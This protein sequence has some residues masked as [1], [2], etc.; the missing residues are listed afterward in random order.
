MPN[1]LNATYGDHQ[2][3]TRY[4]DD[5][6]GS[7]AFWRT[8]Q[9]SAAEEKQEY[10]PRSAVPMN[11]RLSPLNEAPRTS[12]S[13][14]P[15]QSTH[16]SFAIQRPA[17]RVVEEPP[18]ETG[19]EVFRALREAT[20]SHDQ[21][22]AGMD[23]YAVGSL[24]TPHPQPSRTPV[25]SLAIQTLSSR[26][27]SPGPST[28][29]PAMQNSEHL[30]QADSADALPTSKGLNNLRTADNLEKARQGLYERRPDMVL[31]VDN[32]Y[33]RA[34]SEANAFKKAKEEG[35]RGISKFLPT[36]EDLKVIRDVLSDMKVRDSFGRSNH[37]H[38]GSLRHLASDYSVGEGTIFTLLGKLNRPG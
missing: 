28:L 5:A 22:L 10:S 9:A 38:R 20:T 16:A 7:G 27:P 37:G 21:N 6:C 4:G 13:F 8:S 14:A 3:R 24:E 18:I 2:P 17:R 34:Q 31:V 11:D 26:S 1:D 35:A 32:A 33:D 36:R 25:A 19:N 23:P 12:A 15:P 30:A 29:Q